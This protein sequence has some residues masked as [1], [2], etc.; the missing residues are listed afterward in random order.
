MQFLNQWKNFKRVH[1]CILKKIIFVLL[2]TLTYYYHD[3]NSKIL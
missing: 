1:A 2:I 3:W